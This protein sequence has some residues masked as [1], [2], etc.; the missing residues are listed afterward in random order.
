MQSKEL[1][2]KYAGGRH[3]EKHPTVYAERFVAFLKKHNFDGLIVD[4][5]CG[6]GRDL[7][8]F[9]KLGF[10]ALGVDNSKKEIESNKNRLPE[11]N[12]E[13]Q[14]VEKLLFKNNSVDAFFMINVIHYVDKE[15]AMREIYRTLKHQGY[16]FIHFNI[17]II[18]KNGNVDYHHDSED[19]LKLV[20][21]FKI[22][23][24]KLFE[25][26]DPQP[27]EHKHTIMEL[28]LQKI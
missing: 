13:V 20:S 4:L 16:F 3:W 28:I 11:L 2:Q 23:H 1:Y 7:A 14:D 22:I 12:F 10:D 5:G 17:D 24:Q 8:V 21:S 25:R 26:I 27:V 9:S 18:D 19:I 15:K 6:N